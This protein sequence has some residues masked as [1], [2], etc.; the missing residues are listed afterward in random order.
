MPSQRPDCD[1]CTGD[2]ARE[3]RADPRTMAARRRGVGGTQPRTSAARGRH[4]SADDHSSSPRRRRDLAADDGSSSPRRRRDPAADDGSA[5]PVRGRSWLEPRRRRDVSP[6]T[7]R[8]GAAARNASPRKIRVGA[9]AVASPQT[10]P[11]TNGRLATAASPRPVDDPRRRRDRCA[12][13][14]RAYSDHCSSSNA[15]RSASARRP[16]I[17]ARRG[18]TRPRASV[19]INAARMAA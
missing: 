12:R 10:I 14:R 13:R 18:A 1:A 5:S 16:E 15:A 7:I 17:D 9:A 11:S 8:V 19:I 2:L 3:P 4:P 6:R